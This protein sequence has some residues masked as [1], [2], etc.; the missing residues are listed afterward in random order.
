MAATSDAP[1]DTTMMR[2]VHDALR[3]DLA[4]ARD[5]L[6]R[7]DAR[8][9]GAA[10]RHRRAPPVDDALP[11][12]PPRLG[13][14]RAL[15]PGPGACRWF[16]RRGRGARPHGPGARGDRTS[17]GCGDDGRDP[18]SRP[19]PPTTPSQQTVA[20]L[21]ALGGRPPPAPAGGGGRGHADRL[22]VRHR[23]GVAGARE[24]AQPRPEVD[25]GARVRG[26][27]ADRRRRRCRPRHRARARAARPEVRPPARLREAVPAA[28]R[29]LLGS[30][31]EAAAPRAT[32]ERGH[33]D[34]RRRHRRG[35]GGRP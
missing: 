8:R 20:A 25:V 18:S 6:D 5:A 12:R 30:R 16:A 27:L 32:G 31:D 9:R 22:A 10:A 14:R 13:G 7:P 24:G 15:P 4:R 28:R 35:L 19:T 21:D 29:G 17:R 3:R 34:G 33:R 2:I 1:A 26:A 23:G 11:A